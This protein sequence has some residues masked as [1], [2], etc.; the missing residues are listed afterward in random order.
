MAVGTQELDA[1][2]RKFAN[3]VDA[4]QGLTTRLVECRSL[5]E[6]DGLRDTLLDGLLAFVDDVSFLAKYGRVATASDQL[7]RD[8]RPPGTV[9]PDP[10]GDSPDQD[11]AA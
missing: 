11:Q 4:F 8:W 5:S 2:R 10:S 6:R 3:R 7:E 9:H 1:L